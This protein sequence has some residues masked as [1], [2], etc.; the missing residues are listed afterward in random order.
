MRVLMLEE[1]QLIR[2]MLLNKFQKQSWQVDFSDELKLLK[3]IQANIY[4]KEYD[5]LII[6]VNRYNQ[7]IIEQT[8]LITDQIPVLFLTVNAHEILLT[9]N[10]QILTKPFSPAK[11]IDAINKLLSQINDFNQPELENKK[12]NEA[13]EEIFDIITRHFKIEFST[14]KVYVADY[15]I[16]PLT[17][18]EYELLKTLV[19][20]P[21]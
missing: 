20:K 14:R 13:E 6:D 8:Q 2:D 5:L 7:Q 1:K 18:K 3:I 9:N 19:Q 15:L 11:L 16:N 4:I 10:V 17:V 21:R 12:N